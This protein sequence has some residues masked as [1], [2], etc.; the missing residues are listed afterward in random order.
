MHVRRW[1]I[2]GDPGEPEARHRPNGAGHLRPDGYITTRRR[3]HPLAGARGYVY[4]HRANLYDK[5]GPGFHS[6]HWCGTSVAWESSTSKL[7][8][9]HLDWDRRNNSPENLA[10]SCLPCNSK[11][12]E[13]RT[14]RGEENPTAKLTEP[15]VLAIRESNERYRALADQYGVSES[16][17]ALIKTGRVWGWLEAPVENA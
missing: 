6:C 16:L 9:D 13:E 14:D 10:P 11:R 12:Y 1:R 4:V 8:A 17:I 5:I 3:D 2:T 15:E 7:T